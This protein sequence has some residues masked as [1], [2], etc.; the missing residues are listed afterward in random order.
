MCGKCH[1]SNEFSKDTNLKATATT[2]LIL[3]IKL[4]MHDLEQHW[5]AIINIKYSSR[6]NELLG[7]S[8]E[9]TKKLL[10]LIGVQTTHKTSLG[11]HAVV[12]T[13]L[14]VTHELEITCELGATRDH[15]YTHFLR[16]GH[17]VEQ[18]VKLLDQLCSPQIY[19]RPDLE[20]LREAQRVLRILRTLRASARVFWTAIKTSPTQKHNECW[21]A[22]QSG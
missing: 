9:E 19:P 7:L 8:D 22:L 11:T 18:P 3:F 10:N 15:R 12:L 2:A 6:L 4:V 1:E 14:A 13:N 16:I 5:W 17:I 21:N 20:V